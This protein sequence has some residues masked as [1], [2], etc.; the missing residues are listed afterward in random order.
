MT[1]LRVYTGELM[2]QRHDDKAYRFS[3]PYA[4][5]CVDIAT[6]QAQC[7]QAG[8][9]SNRWGLFSL[10][11]TDFG[12]RKGTPW[13]TWLRNCLA[14]HHFFADIHRAELVAVPRFLGI[15]FNPLA[16]WYA[17]NE[18][19]DVIATIAEVSNT[20]GQWHHYVHH[21]NGDPIDLQRP[22]SA[23]KAFHV[24]PFLPMPLHYVFKIRPPSEDYRVIIE[25]N[26]NQHE[27]VLTAVQTGQLCQS[28]NLIGCLWQKGLTS[29]GILF[30]IHWH[31]FKLWR[32]NAKFFK[33]P[34]HLNSVQHSDSRMTLCP[35]PSTI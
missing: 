28:P 20:F 9:R 8:I 15:G 13:P 30:G 5:V 27:R 18:Q 25:E 31:A 17:Y 29:F 26:N 35:P 6:W 22:F 3:Y 2:H 14:K 32:R 4:V 10:H 1:P 16:M 7:Q 11:Q 34:I 19:G 23:D 24:S 21:L 12:D 33:T